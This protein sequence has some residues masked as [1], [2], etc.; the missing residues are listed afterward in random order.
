MF[1]K[2]NS[3]T[4]LFNV[5]M[6]PL[7][8]GV[9]EFNF[10]AMPPSASATASRTVHIL[11]PIR[12]VKVITPF[13][14]LDNLKTLNVT[15]LQFKDAISTGFNINVN[16]TSGSNI[17]ASL[18]WGDGDVETSVLPA[19]LNHVYSTGGDYNVTITVSSPLG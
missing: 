10:A 19:N 3:S 4:G 17:T 13:G 1:A 2:F 12:G 8:E 5:V 15:Q 18:D 7:S 6:P 9:Y 16:V 14:A 11:D